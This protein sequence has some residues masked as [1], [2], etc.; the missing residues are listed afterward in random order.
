MCNEQDR[1]YVMAFGVG[2]MGNIRC[3]YD[4]FFN[5]L[6]SFVMSFVLCGFRKNI[7]KK[8]V[9]FILIIMYFFSLIIV[10]KIKIIR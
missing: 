4:V 7:L 3:F 2:S 10:D 6:H 5:E 1:V 9:I 8:Y